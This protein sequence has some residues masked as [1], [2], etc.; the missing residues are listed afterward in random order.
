MAEVVGQGNLL[1]DPADLL[2]YEADGL[3]HGRTRP[4]LVV[5]P[6]S[7]D[8][9]VRIVAIAREARIPLVPRGPGPLSGGAR[10]VEG[11][12]VVSADPRGGPRERLYAPDPSSHG[13]C[14]IGGN[15]AE[16]SR[17]AFHIVP[18]RGKE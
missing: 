18:S 11:G 12:A 10:P 1:T 14:S 2:V 13:V 16:N 4:A 5:L 17:V 3:T 15:V 6:G 7:T 9:V 8:E